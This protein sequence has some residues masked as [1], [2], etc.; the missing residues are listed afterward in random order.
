MPTK[1]QRRR[2]QKERRHEYETVWVDEEGN[3]LEE[4]PE[5]LVETRDKRDGSK[6]KAK[7]TQQRG[8]R[9]IRVPPAPSWQR[10][11][12]RSLILGVVIFA[13]V[14]LLGAKNGQHSFGAALG[15]AG[16]YTLLFIPL[17]YMFDRFA[18]NRWQRRADQQAAKRPARKR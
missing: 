8:G 17:G 10:A 7:A 5:D 18:H 14:Y 6:P 4:P 13:V 16:L 11:A 2:A 3:E 1:K 15:F 9:P 12:R